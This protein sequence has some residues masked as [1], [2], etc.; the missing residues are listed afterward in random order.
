M[1]NANSTITR[2]VRIALVT[3]CKEVTYPVGLN[4]R[5]T[6]SLPVTT[7]MNLGPTNLSEAIYQC[8]GFMDQ[9]QAAAILAMKPNVAAPGEASSTQELLTNLLQSKSSVTSKRTSTHER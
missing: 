1:I 5:A 2:C 9:G 3:A 8:E 6:S 7:T 4:V